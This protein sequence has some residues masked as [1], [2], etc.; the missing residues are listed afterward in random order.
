VFRREFL[1]IGNIEVFLESVTIA[2][3]CNRVLRKRYLKPGTI[4]YIPTGGIQVT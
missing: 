2:S 4:G 1:A 3:A